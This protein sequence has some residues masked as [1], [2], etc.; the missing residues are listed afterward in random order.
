MVRLS[1]ETDLWVNK[2]APYTH[3]KHLF[4]VSPPGL[5]AWSKSVSLIELHSLPESV[6]SR[7]G[8][9]SKGEAPL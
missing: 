8:G 3:G 9:E 6:W 1:F 7:G 4:C 2:A 5:L